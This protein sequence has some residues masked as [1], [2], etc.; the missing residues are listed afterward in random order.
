M[1]LFYFLF[2]FSTKLNPL[3]FLAIPPIENQRPSD[4]C[5]PNP[6]GPYSECRSIG[7]TPF[8]IC[9]QN[10][11]GSPPNCRPECIMDSE[12]SNNQACI[13]EKCRDPCPGSCGFLS[14]C[15]VVNHTP[16]CSCLKG[17]TGNAFQ[18]CFPKPTEE[19]KNQS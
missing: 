18:Q 1:R 17:Y 11:I 16:I 5:I 19:R 3:I 12:C 6:C 10:F 2:D 15:N 9:L 14:E 7:V 13:N 4:P 8:C